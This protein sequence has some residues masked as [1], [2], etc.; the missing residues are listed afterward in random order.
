LPEVELPASAVATQEDDD[1]VEVTIE[2]MAMNVLV[3][4]VVLAQMGAGV[5][6]D[7]GVVTTGEVD[8]MIG[9]DVDFTMPVEVE[10][11]STDNVGADEM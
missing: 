5:E 3:A 7:N 1:W 4:K 9:I 10:G 6:V 8:R 11:V 2:E